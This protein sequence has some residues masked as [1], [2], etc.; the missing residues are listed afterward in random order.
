MPMVY[1]PPV[2][3]CA[4]PPGARA[5]ARASQ[6][7]RDR[8]AK[9]LTVPSPRRARWVEIPDGAGEDSPTDSGRRHS[10]A[11]ILQRSPEP[12]KIA[13]PLP[14]RHLTTLWPRPCVHPWRGPPPRGTASMSSAP[15]PTTTLERP[16][17]GPVRSAAAASPANSRPAPAVVPHGS[18]ESPFSEGCRRFADILVSATALLL[19]MPVFALVAVAIKTTSPGPILYR[20]VRVGQNRRRHSRR[21]PGDTRG[22]ADRRTRSDRRRSTAYGRPFTIW[23]F[24]TMVINAEEYGPQW[25]SRFDPRITAVGR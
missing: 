15:T 21:A 7:P 25:S 18:F 4:I 23:K 22:S 8:V 2:W 10:V 19:L 11:R 12:N 5:S 3:A 14:G 17:L 1:S 24:R 20:Q 13:K 6:T 9:Q 16:R